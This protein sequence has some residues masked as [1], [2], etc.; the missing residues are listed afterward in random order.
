MTAVDLPAFLETF[1]TVAA[2]FNVRRDEDRLGEVYFKALQAF[3]IRQVQA[4]GERCAACLKRFPKPVEW[5]KLIPRPT[6]PGILELTACEAADYL[7][8]ESCGYELPPCRCASCGQAG[9]SSRPLRYVP[10]DDERT[11]RLGERL[12]IRGHWAH[13]AELARW[14]AAKE[15][16]WAKARALGHPASL[17]QPPAGRRRRR[18]SALALV[19]AREPGEDD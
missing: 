1:R 3:P 8:A 5:K 12:V 2:T 15:A 11:F 18:A 19:A 14:Y 6:A 7:E 10:D 17:L 16:F 9:V 13:G 4:G